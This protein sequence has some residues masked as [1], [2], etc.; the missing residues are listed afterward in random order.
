MLSPQA[1][2]FVSHAVIFFSVSSHKVS[3]PKKKEKHKNGCMV[4]MYYEIENRIP[5]VSFQEQNGC[6]KSS[7]ATC[8]NALNNRSWGWWKYKLINW[9]TSR[10]TNFASKTYDLKYD[11]TKKYL[12]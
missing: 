12:L 2:K 4:Y 11:I 7:K 6:P 9:G 5:A 8:N 1:Q 3:S 10:L